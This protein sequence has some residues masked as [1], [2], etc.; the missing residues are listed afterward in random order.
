MKNLKAAATLLLWSSVSALAADLPS[1]KSAPV[2]APAPM[3]TGFYA[4]LNIGYGF[5]TS[6]GSY[7]S[8]YP[9]LDTWD[10]AQ[11]TARGLLSFKDNSQGIT[12]GNAGNAPM[13]QNGV[14]GGGQIGYNLQLQDRYV[15][16]FE[17]DIQGTGITGNGKSYNLSRGELD[18]SF[19]SGT[20]RD[21]YSRLVFGQNAI[22]ASVDWLGTA[23]LRA[24]YLI[25][26]TLLAYGTGGLTYGGITAT[27][28][29][30]AIAG[31]YGDLTGTFRGWQGSVGLQGNSNTLAVGWNAGGGVEWMF[32][33]NWSAK[34]EAIYYDLGAQTLTSYT[35]GPEYTFRG[36][37]FSNPTGA[38]LVQNNNT[39]SYN[40]IIARAGVNYHFNFANV[41]PVVAKF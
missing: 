7:T 17:A 14:I 20:P 8:A 29:P 2:A 16:G 35:Y 13:T 32:M 5:G 4:G 22:S 34:A 39:I 10:D 30:G 25:T 37:G 31:Y 40:G 33:Q 26:P 11:A 3:W 18:Y 1:I 27:S 24:G 23:R 21:G 19:R 6:N 9:L 41:A 36:T 15:I 12:F 38:W 28:S